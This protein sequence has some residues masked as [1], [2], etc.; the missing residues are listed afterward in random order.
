MNRKFKAFT[1][2]ELLVVIAIIAI[3]AAILFPVF[4]QAKQSAKRTQDLSNMK[5]LALAG[6]MYAGDSDDVLLAF[7]Y[8]GR[9]STPQYPNPGDFNGR[10]FWSDLIMPYVKSRGLFSNAS[11]SDTLYGPGGY[12]FPGQRDATDTDVNNR[13]R[14]TAALNHMISRADFPPLTSGATSAS[15]VDVPSEI[16]MTGPSQYAWTWSSCQERNGEVLWFWNVSTGGWGYEFFGA[17]NNANAIPNAGMN[18]GANFSFIDGHARF[19]KVTRGGAL[20]SATPSSDG[21]YSGYF[22]TIKTSNKAAPAGTCPTG[23]T[24]GIGAFAY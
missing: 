14:V 19:G 9:W 4:A 12:L 10:A 21:L 15:S 8:A 20:G 18:G 5:Q 6:L 24:P 17:M 23:G 11:N 7:P 22:P 2:I 3:L 13:Y 1:L 16:A